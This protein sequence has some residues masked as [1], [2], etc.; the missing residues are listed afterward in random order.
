VLEAGDATYSQRFGSGITRQDIINLL[1]DSPGTTVAGDLGEKDLLG[2]SDYDCH[3]LTQFLQFIFDVGAAIR[4]LH[5]SLAPGGVVLATAPGLSPIDPA[6][7]GSKWYWSFTEA[8]LRTLFEEVFGRGNVQVASH[9]N[10]LAATC[11]IHGIALEE[12]GDQWLEPDDPAYPVIITVR[13]QR[14]A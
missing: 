11:F 9:G 2:A 1:P 12:I 6:A 13:A 8:S 5:D 4:R 3:V 10:A 14:A 7:D